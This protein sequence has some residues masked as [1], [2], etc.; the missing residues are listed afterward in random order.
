MKISLFLF[1]LFFNAFFPFYF[2]SF[3]PI[4]HFHI[5]PSFFIQT[6]MN[7]LLVPIIVI[8]MQHV[9]TQKVLS[10]V[11]ATVDLQE[12]EPHVLVSTFNENIF[13]LFYLFFNAF[14][15]FFFISFFPI[16][17]FHYKLSF[18]YTDNNECTL[19]THNCHSNA[20]CTN[21]EGSFTCACNSGFTGIG[22]TCS[23]ELLCL[24]CFFFLSLLFCNPSSLLLHEFDP[25]L[26]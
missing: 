8:Q 7:V 6:T 5:K 1:Y 24:K 15:P 9:P 17:H 25:F 3:F 19:A 4:K 26:H 18:I 12:M 13:F 14:V 20:T 21:T 23:G 2:I 10:L 16:K 11:L 22:T